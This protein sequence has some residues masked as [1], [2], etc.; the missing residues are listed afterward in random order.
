MHKIRISLLFWIYCAVLVTFNEFIALFFPKGVMRIGYI[1]L[2][3][4]FGTVTLYKQKY[5]IDASRMDLLVTIY[6]MYVFLRGI[7]QHINGVTIIGT[8]TAWLQSLIPI[9]S[10]FIAS[11]L[12]KK[13]KKTVETLFALF[14]FISVTVGML[15]IKFHFLPAVGTFAGKLYAY[16]GNNTF[17]VRGYSLADIALITGFISGFSMCCLI[18]LDINIKRKAV[19]FVV[20]LAGCL[21]SLSRGALAFVVIAILSYLIFRCL[22]GLCLNGHYKISKKKALCIVLITIPLLIVAIVNLDKITNSAIFNRFIK[23]GL[24]QSEGSNN[25]RTEYQKIA[26]SVI[27]KAPIVGIGYGFTGYQAINA[28]IEN[29]INTESYILSLGISS[30]LI[31]LLLFILIAFFSIFKSRKDEKNMKYIGAVIGM[32]AWSVMYILLDSDLIGLFY[33]YCIGALNERKHNE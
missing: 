7:F 32:L 29:T 30:G 5:R 3:M 31:G 27:S 6:F 24:S 16:V 28:G 13:E 18:D 10:Y 2:M 4:L 26:L 19:L 1:L 22:N 25:I 14:S 15:N 12:N 9:F 23:I 33:W 8:T 17:V 21:Y 11:D 20:N